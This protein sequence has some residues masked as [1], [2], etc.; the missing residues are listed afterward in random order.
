MDR[1]HHIAIIGHGCRSDRSGDSK[2]SDFH[3]AIRSH[4]D[5][6]RLNIAMYQMIRV[7]VRQSTGNLPSN[8]Q[9]QIH[10]KRPFA[11]NE[12]LQ[13]LARNVF[14]D[15]VMTVFVFPH[16]IDTDDIR[17]GKAGR[18]LRLLLKAPQELFITG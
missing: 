14:H 10:R 13:R 9:G 4:K 16:I 6:M 5:I 1:S 12:S 8:P 7:G 3:P 11:L 15:D 17:M 18:S 2:V